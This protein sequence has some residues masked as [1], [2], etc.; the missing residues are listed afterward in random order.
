[1]PVTA[2]F[3]ADHQVLIAEIRRLHAKH[4]DLIAHEMAIEVREGEPGREVYEAAIAASEV[5]CNELHDFCYRILDQPVCSWDDVAVRAE[6]AKAF[7]EEELDGGLSIVE[8]PG[9]IGDET[10]AA[11]LEA[12]LLMGGAN[13]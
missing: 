13:V 11:L 12:A 8:S 9:D 4:Q 3:P 10:L 7:A 1:M 5:A 6:L 2:A